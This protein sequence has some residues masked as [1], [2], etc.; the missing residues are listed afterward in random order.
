MKKEDIVD[1][2]RKAWNKY[3]DEKISWSIPVD[4]ETVK[5]A[6]KGNWNIILTPTKPVPKGWM[7]YVKGK[8]ILC[9]A[10]GGGQQGPILA[11][12]GAYVTVFD[13]SQKQLKQDDLVAQRENLKIKTVL[14]DMRNLS[15]FVNE[16][17][18]LIIH[19][20]SNCFVPELEPVWKES[21]RVLKYGGSLLS[22]FSKPEM[23]LFTDEDIEKGNLIVKNKLPYCT[24]EETKGDMESYSKT[25]RA[26]E[27]SHTLE[28]Q[29]GGQI[30]AGFS[31]TGFYEDVFED[32]LLS[33][34]F[35]TFIA[36]RASK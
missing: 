3:V 32:D 1:Y 26:V 2:N 30:K 14:G 12:A 25:G 8:R 31:I 18:D 11:A 5:N 33:K 28:N 17:F 34:Y 27:Y 4:H 22:G 15:C 16:Y 10:S 20:V 19:P 13:N 36:T 35:P 9:L 23:Y 7:G 21:Y 29:I 6:I 24:L